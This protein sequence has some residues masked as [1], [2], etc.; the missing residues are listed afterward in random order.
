MYETDTIAAVATPAGHGGVGIV[1]I[2]G[3]QAL[4]IAGVLFRRATSDTTWRSRHLYA[5]S[6]TD[7]HGRLIDQGLAVVM[8]GPRSFT[9]EDV[10]EFHCHGSPVVLRQVLTSVLA[11]GA[12]PAS[13]GEFTRRAFLNGRIDLTQ[14]E[15]VIDLVSARTEAGAAMAVRQLAGHLSAHL[16]KLRDGLTHLLALLEVQI[17]FS[18]EDVGVDAD[19]ATRAA[20][21]SLTTLDDLLESYRHGKAIRDGARVAIIGKPNVGKSSL[22]NAL[23]GV[24]RAIV[25]PL[26]GTTRDTIEECVDLDGLPVVLVDTAG[27]HGPDGIETVEALGIARARAAMQTADLLLAVV[28]ASQPIDERDIEV[29]AAA[30]ASPRVL[31]LNKLDLGL[32]LAPADIGRLQNGAGVVQVS[33]TAGRGLDTLRERIRAC[34]LSDV[35]AHREGPVLSSVRHRDALEKARRSLALARQALSDGFAAELVAIDVRDALDHIGGVTG[36]VTTEDVL[37]DVFSRFCIGK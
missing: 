17:D 14:A 10:I 11:L 23:L 20:E 34:L 18:D 24:D 29:M 4:Q 35:E 3:P 2:S 26:A 6:V 28:D 32:R 19:T 37:D 13:P 8:R 1:R 36:V 33:A 21:K 5:G 27:L 9:G 22:L 12:R 31:V 25:N 30:G 16:D 7:P 15:A